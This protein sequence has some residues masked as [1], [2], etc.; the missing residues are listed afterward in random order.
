MA[1]LVLGIVM[2][3]GACS[4]GGSSTPASTGGNTPIQNNTQGTEAASGIGQGIDMALGTT[5][6][7]G[8]LGN[9][10][11]LAETGIQAPPPGTF[12]NF[13]QSPA[14]G[15]LVGV[16]S[17]FAAAQL[18]A[19]AAKGATVPHVLSLSFPITCTDGGLITL[20]TSTT[21]LALIFS[22]CRENHVQADGEYDISSFGTTTSG[23]S[24]IGTLGSAATPTA[25][26]LQDY[27]PGGYNA[28]NLISTT[29]V[30]GLP[31]DLTFTSSGSTVTSASIY[32]AAGSMSI[33]DINTSQTYSV[34]LTGWS[35]AYALSTSA[36]GTTTTITTNGTIAES[37]GSDS[38]TAMFT[39]FQLA[40][41]PDTAT[42][43]EDMSISGTFTIAYTPPAICQD[44][45]GMFTV[46]TDS[47]IVFDDTTGN[48]ISGELTLNGATTITYNAD[49]SITVTTG[50]DSQTYDNGYDL[51]QVCQYGTLGGPAIYTVTY[52]S[53]G[54][55]GS[56]PVDSTIYEQGQAVTVLGSGSL[57]YPGNIFAGWNTAADG[58]GTTYA[59]GK[60]FT[61]GTADVTLYAQWTLVIGYA[62][63]ANKG[64]G[65]P[66]GNI[67][68]YAIAS[69]GA[70]ISMSTPT[71]AAGSGS[72]PWSVA[73]DPLGKYLYMADYG[74]GNVYQ[75]TINS[76]G[77][78][79]AMN[80]PSVS[81]GASASSVVVDPTGPY[82]YVANEGGATIAQF[83]I[84]GN[85]SLTNMTLVGS[86]AAPY[87]LATDP[88][89]S[90]LY[91]ANDAV[92]GTV[93]LYDISTG[94]TLSFEGSIT[95]GEFPLAIT[96]DPT[97]PYVY[98]A[99][100][101]NFTGAIY[102]YQIGVD[103]VLSSLTP[104]TEP[105]GSVA[106]AI[107]VDP[108]GTYVYVANFGDN[109]ITQYEI[110]SGG[111]LSAL[112]PPTVAAGTSPTGVAVD[113]TGHYVYV[114]NEDHTVWQYTI[115][116]GGGLVSMTTPTVAAGSSPWAIVTVGIH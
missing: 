109:D 76:D 25:F 81:A 70:L 50:G 26:T 116:P 111:T 36:S 15:R 86:V 107:A 97:G 67:S 69:G 13:E 82:V 44:G 113:P 74:Y 87:A 11:L 54:A 90:F 21:G 40:I 71:V 42:Q 51:T 10:G 19:A 57:A 63:V 85:G 16:T 39:N 77:S 73:A 100:S 34:T 65:D 33:N 64:P 55:G 95:A 102:Q 48:T 93:S 94:G 104:N 35:D 112:S 80:P 23:Y 53:N 3:L 12:G 83:T 14:I 6:A 59:P 2:F 28:A 114:T 68:Q 89:G 72:E 99:S 41:T 31:M 9:I 7:F 47:P 18:A 101:M 43:T 8:N 24:L 98:A 37:W 45:S 108:T 103:G 38:L 61:M 66:I 110:V 62:Y 56:V 91:V 32:I 92:S 60:T 88:T 58:S 79:K 96:V 49:G 20:G 105:A 30:T 75:F 4:S 1:V 5:L 22:A 106:H 78:L 17:K 46:A 84:S 27:G 52:M 115:G 29:T